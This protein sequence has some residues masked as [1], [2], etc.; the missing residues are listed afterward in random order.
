MVHVSVKQ[1]PATDVTVLERMQTTVKV[2]GTIIRTGSEG[3][4]LGF[5][6]KYDDN[7]AVAV[8]TAQAAEA[9]NLKPITSAAVYT[10]IGNIGALLETI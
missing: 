6:L 10:E 5:G 8:D 4:N 1:T 9:E 3:L 2:D 7:G